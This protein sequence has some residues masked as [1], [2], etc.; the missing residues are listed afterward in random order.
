M[1]CQSGV[2]GVLYTCTQMHVE[3]HVATARARI[4][5]GGVHRVGATAPRSH[6]RRRQREQEWASAFSRPV[7]DA[8]ARQPSESGSG[9]RA[10]PDPSAQLRKWLDEEQPWSVAGRALL[11]DRGGRLEAQLTELVILDKNPLKVEPMAIKDIKVVETIKKG[12]TVY[13]AN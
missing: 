6:G 9:H 7:G 3:A 4:R 5:K 1:R 13:E 12:K 2:G 8:G 10:K 11:V